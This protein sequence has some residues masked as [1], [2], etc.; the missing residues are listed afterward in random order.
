[1]PMY[2]FR[3]AACDQRFEA[4]VDAGTADS[5]CRICGAPGATRILSA[6]AAPF[7]VAQTVGQARKRE[8]ANAALHGDA[9][10]DFKAKREQARKRKRS[11]S[12][13]S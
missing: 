6:Q 10:A 13:E 7:G 8:R 4:L 1:M 12:G 5:E 11:E 2:E 3:C 9:K